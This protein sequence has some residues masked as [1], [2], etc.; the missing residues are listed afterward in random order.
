MERTGAKAKGVA[1]KS[2]STRRRRNKP[3]SHGDAEPAEAAAAKK[4]PRRLGLAN[5]DP[6]ISDLWDA[7]QDSAEAKFYSDADWHRVRLELRYGNHVLRELQVGYAAGFDKQGEVI[8]GNKIN[9]AAWTAFQNALTELLI[10]PASKRRA[11]I[12]VKPPVGKSA[13]E[14]STDAKIIQIAA[15]LKQA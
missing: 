1:P 3:K 7:V 8:V 12:D 15:A 10:S 4:P 9:S 13:E 6:M 2:N 14:Q 11:G 5:P